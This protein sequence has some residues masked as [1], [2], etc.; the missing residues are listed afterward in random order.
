MSASK[1]SIDVRVRSYFTAFIDIL[2]VDAR[3]R[4]LDAQAVTGELTEDVKRAIGENTFQIREFRK[5]FDDFY[6]TPIPP[7]GQ[8]A[9][10]HPCCDSQ[11]PSVPFEDPIIK[12]FS[13]SVIVSVPVNSTNISSVY[14]SY[15]RLALGCVAAQFKML[16]FGVLIRGGISIGYGNE[17]AADEVITAGFK[18]ASN[19]ESDKRHRMPRV[20]I[21]KEIDVGMAPPAFWESGTLEQRWCTGLWNLTNR[22]IARDQEGIAYLNFLG[23]EVIA[24]ASGPKT[25]EAIPLFVRVIDA[26]LDKNSVRPPISSCDEA[27]QA[28]LKWQ[29]TA[30]YWN[31]NRSE[32]LALAK[33]SKETK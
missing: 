14:S 5:A 1:V 4:A 17:I 25:D 13:D 26:V 7:L 12:A 19:I 30:S 21:D 22:A 33:T 15:Y 11:V 2:G 6:K 3:L 10:K 16:G 8:S 31:D 9:P 27:W 32:V 28:W 23:P 20:S 29:W 24:M 18:K